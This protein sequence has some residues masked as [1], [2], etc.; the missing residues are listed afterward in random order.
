MAT[1]NNYRIPAVD[2]LMKV[3]CQCE[4]SMCYYD[5][6]FRCWSVSTDGHTAHNP[7]IICCSATLGC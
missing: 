7:S 5:I 4:V 6:C 1:I 3:K 2:W